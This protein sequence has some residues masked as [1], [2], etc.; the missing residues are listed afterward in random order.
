MAEWNGSTQPVRLQHMGK[1][2][3]TWSLGRWLLRVAGPPSGPGT[4]FVTL[5]GDNEEPLAEWKLEPGWG[6]Q[7]VLRRAKARAMP[8]EMDTE[9][10]A[11][12][13]VRVLA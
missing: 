11:R 5:L 7:E 9:L 2:E 8:P 12:V 10:L 4:R 3:T 6:P 13:I 1:H